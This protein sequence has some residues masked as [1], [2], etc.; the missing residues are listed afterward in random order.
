MRPYACGDRERRHRAHH[1]HD[2]LAVG[3][4]R[5]ETQ[6]PRER[7]DSPMIHTSQHRPCAGAIEQKQ[8]KGEDHGDEIMTQGPRERL[9]AA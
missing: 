1:V 6:N 9:A 7:L 4:E 8:G 5:G 2:R 3:K